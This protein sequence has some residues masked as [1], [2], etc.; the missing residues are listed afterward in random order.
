LN[1]LNLVFFWISRDK[2]GETFFFTLLAKQ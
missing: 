1:L 2:E